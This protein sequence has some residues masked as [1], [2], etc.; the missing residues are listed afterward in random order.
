MPELPEVETTLRGLAPHVQGAKIEKVV[1][2]HYR[3]RWPVPENFAHSVEQQTVRSIYRRGKYLLLTLDSGS[4]IIH[5]GM[6]GHLCLLDHP[7]PAKRHDHMD[8]L[9]SSQK[10]LRYTDPRRFGSIL[11]TSGDPL[12]HPLLKDLGV[13]P[14]SDAFSAKYLLQRAVNRRIAV[15][16]FIMDSKVVVG[17]GNIYAAEALFKAGIHPITPAGLLTEEQVMR[18]VDA[19]KQ[20]LANAIEQGGTT[21]KDFFNSEG[22]PGYFKQQ[23]NVYGRRG[24]PCPVC[25]KPLQSCVLGQRSTVFCAQCQPMPT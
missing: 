14:L 16:P 3:L 19:I 18:L 22:R 1:I 15:K 10:V 17:V 21:L 4:I 13:E 7:G 12:E 2:R 25:S 24:L 20:I 23:L 9:F 11:L 5:L 6:S 8:I